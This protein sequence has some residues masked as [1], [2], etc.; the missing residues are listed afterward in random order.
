MLG[1]MRPFLSQRMMVARDM[2]ASMA[3]CSVDRV[4]SFGIK[5]PL[6]QTVAYLS[7]FVKTTHG[8]DWIIRVGRSLFDLVSVRITD[9]RDGGESR[10]GLNDCP[11]FAAFT[12]GIGIQGHVSVVVDFEDFARISRRDF[13]Q[14]RDLE[15]VEFQREVLG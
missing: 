3:A 14:I 15:S 13:G 2:P 8:E 9:R 7:G 10:F 12:S 5:P 11:E 6:T 4:S 1:L